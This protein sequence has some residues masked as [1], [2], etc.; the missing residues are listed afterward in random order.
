MIDLITILAQQA[1]DVASDPLGLKSLGIGAGGVVG[2]GIAIYRFIVKP[3]LDAGRAIMAQALAGRESEQK[4]IATM[5]ETLKDATRCSQEAAQSAEAAAKSNE[6]TAEAFE[7]Q[8]DR[9]ER[10]EKGNG[11]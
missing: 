11:S 1:A 8:L 6:R 5:G 3:E 10:I 9:L 2:S 4:A 7:R